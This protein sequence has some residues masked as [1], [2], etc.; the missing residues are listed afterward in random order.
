MEPTDRAAAEIADLATAFA[1]AATAC[2]LDAP[3]SS[4]IDLAA[5]LG[6]LG[7]ADPQAVFAAGQACFCHG[8]EDLDRYAQV[9]AAFFSAGMDALRQQERLHPWPSAK[10]VVP[11]VD[12]STDEEPEQE[13]PTD[14]SEQ[15]VAAYSALE[16]LRRKDFADCSDE[17]LAEI[18]RLIAGLRQ[19]PPRRRSRRTVVSPRRARGRIDVR[20]TVRA[21]LRSGAELQRIHRR[22]RGETERRVVW[23]LDVSGSMRQ[24]A[25][26]ML[27]LA[28]GSVVAQRRAEAFAL[29]T[30]C[31]RI[32]RE[33][34]SRNPD[35]ALDHAAAAAP[36][37]EGGT[38]LGDGLRTFNDGWGIRGLARGAVV[39]ICSDGWDRG[40]PE[41]LGTEM[42]RLHRVAERIVWVNPLKATEGYEPLARGMA[43]ALPSV[44]EF[45]SGH[46]FEA[47]LELVEVIAR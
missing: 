35:A 39:V 21:S 36:D 16:V 12:D 6:V 47:L 7:I 15:V 9:F 10:L 25:R 17:E 2:G 30:R 13:T 34:A 14:R 23:L 44:D 19:H 43:A 1:R 41:L 26:V 4:A 45:C 11:A 42:E 22:R 40:D 5:A 38:R 8:P 3:L 18:S 46:S 28:H 27:L 37:L 20:A 32:T 31:T 29:S 33:L 24:Y